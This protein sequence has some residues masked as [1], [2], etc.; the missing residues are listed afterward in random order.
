MSEEGQKR[1]PQLMWA[2]AERGAERGDT[3]LLSRPLTSRE[4]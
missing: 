3:R 2:Q 4:K 1:L